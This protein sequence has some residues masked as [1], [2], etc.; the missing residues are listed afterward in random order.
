MIIVYGANGS[1]GA[2]YQAILRSLY[3]DVFPVDVDTPINSVPHH[4]ANG[5]IVATPTDTHLAFVE[6][7][8]SI[9]NSCP[10]LCEKP[11]SK[12]LK[13]VKR[14]C[15]LM[16]RGAPISMVS[17]YDEL[18]SAF[19]RGLTSYD[20]FRTGK[21]GL[22]W[23]CIQIIGLA[24]FLPMIANQSPIWKCSINGR[25]LNL[26]DMD[27]AYVKM[28]K[29]W[30]INGKYGWSHHRILSAHEKAAKIE[31]ELMNEKA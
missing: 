31:K 27:G 23:D 13:E 21:D 5:Y 11:I 14:F 12:D 3:K 25:P 22:A 24:Q 2:R 16:S 26:A 19:D 29:S 4:L 15:D 6:S 30:L 10:I 9:N 17:Q 18:V 8:L 1:M 20:Y 7:L 28:I